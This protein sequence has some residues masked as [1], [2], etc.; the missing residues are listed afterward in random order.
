MHTHTTKTDEYTSRQR[1]KDAL[2]VREYEAWLATLTPE[3]RY[4]AKQL[5]VDAPLLPSD[6]NGIH[7][8]DLADS[9]LASVPAF[10]I[11]EPEPAEKS[12]QSDTSDRSVQIPSQA[13]H[14]EEVWDILRRLIGQLMAER[15]ARLSLEC[16][17]LVSGMSFL[18]DSMT[19]IARWHGVTRAAVSKRCVELTNQL[20]LLP[21]RAMRSLSARSAYRAAQ[22]S[23]RA[24]YERFGNSPVSHA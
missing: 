8:E 15:N 23:T 3:E 12:D 7:D 10:E 17:A 11:Q 22:N 24:H 21:S 9:P 5:G 16:L 4:T 14:S 20:N 13:L 2:Y 1:A 19:A 18:G 6:G